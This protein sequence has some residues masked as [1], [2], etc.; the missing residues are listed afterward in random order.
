MQDRIE[1]IARAIKADNRPI[2]PENLPEN[3][4][5]MPAVPGAYVLILR[6]ARPVRAVTRRSIDC[7]IPPGWH[8]YA[9]S[10][11]GPGGIRARL[12][13]HFRND[14]AVHWH[15]D[16]LT[17]VAEELAAIAVEGGAECDLVGRLLR[18]GRYRAAVS[19]FG[20]TDC[21]CCETHLL[22]AT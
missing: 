6:L 5:D 16:R 22:T 21:R 12:M 19:G 14:K 4:N 8:V 17:L 15:I 7:S 20:N 11:R 13:R 18:S 10:A 9:G 1:A 2:T 3:L